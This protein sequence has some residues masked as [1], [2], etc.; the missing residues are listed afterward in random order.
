MFPENLY[1]LQGLKF[2]RIELQARPAKKLR[3]DQINVKKLP[4]LEDVH[5]YFITTFNNESERLKLIFPSYSFI[6]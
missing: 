2:M 3:I 5:I 4:D 6:N 1:F